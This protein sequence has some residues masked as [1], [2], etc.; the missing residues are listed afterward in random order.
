MDNPLPFII[1]IAITLALVITLA[2]I[3]RPQKNRPSR[4][5]GRT[6]ASDAG[7]TSMPLWFSAGSH[8][9]SDSGGHSGGYSGGDSGGSDG[10]GGGG[11]E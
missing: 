2:L 3:M 11:G 9:D 6:N 1:F 4:T 8:H 5:T 10:G 7:D